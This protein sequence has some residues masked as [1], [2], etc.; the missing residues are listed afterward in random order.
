MENDLGKLE[1]TYGR[2]D[3]ALRDYLTAPFFDHKHKIK[4]PGYEPQ[5]G[6]KNMK[7]ININRFFM[8]N[9]AAIL[10]LGL[11]QVQAQTKKSVKT[12]PKTPPVSQNQKEAIE[13]I[14]REYLLKNPTVIREAMLALQ[15]QEEKEKQ[16][17]FANNKKELKSEI[18][19]DV[20]S[21]VAGNAKGD[22]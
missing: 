5:T 3:N 8:I 15:V 1:T 6:E 12:N 4:E 22:V 21:P 9:L 19:S 10:F 11:F 18:Y 2:N 14:I 7:S 20:D 16:Q 13:T 17:A